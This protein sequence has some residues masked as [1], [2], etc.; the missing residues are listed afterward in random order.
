M[1]FEGASKGQSGVSGYERY[2]PTAKDIPSWYRNV[3]GSRSSMCQEYSVEAVFHSDGATCRRREGRQFTHPTIV[4]FFFA[5][6][7]RPGPTMA[8]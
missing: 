3:E 4:F 2:L 5:Q 8:A 7:W 1:A 6:A